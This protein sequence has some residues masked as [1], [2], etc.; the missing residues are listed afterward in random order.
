MKG[1]FVSLVVFAGVVSAVSLLGM[2]PVKAQT[3][4]TPGA[5][6]VTNDGHPAVRAAY[7]TVSLGGAAHSVA[8]EVILPK[9]VTP[10][11][12]YTYTLTWQDD[13]TGTAATGADPNNTI[14]TSSSLAVGT[15][16]ADS[17]YFGALAN[18]VKSAT[19]DKNYNAVGL[20]IEK[21]VGPEG[22]AVSLD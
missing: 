7:S 17:N 1:K 15:L 19:T 6:F 16:N 11:G 2:Q 8:T 5:T 12:P 9:S 21:F 20:M 4:V 22:A 18:A 13:P 3:T 14:L 10:E